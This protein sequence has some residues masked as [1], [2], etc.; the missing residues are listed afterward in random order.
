MIEGID[1]AWAHPVPAALVAAGKR[2]ACRYLSRDPGKN[3][4]AAEA[5]QLHAAG[6]ATVSNW[7]AA[8]GAARNGYAQGVA[9][10][11]AA[12]AQHAAA[13][14]PADRPIYFSVDFDVPDFAP[15][16]ADP[17]AKL[18]AVAGYFR[19]VASVIGVARTGAYGGFWAISRLFDAGLIRWGWQTFAWSGGHW[20]AR[21]QIQQYSNGV[22]VGGADSDLDRATVADYG[23]WG[24]GMTDINTPIPGTETPDHKIPRT[25]GEIEHDEAVDRA[26]RWGQR[27]VTDMPAD[28][29]GRKLLE[30]PDV[31]A[32]LAARLDALEAKLTAPVTVVL[33]AADREDI[34]A[35]MAVQ[36]VAQLGALRFEAAPPAAS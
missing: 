26:I 6:I 12:A 34:A 17:A 19:G 2:F 21:A 27:P 8:S 18:G 16:S 7:E 13:G 35:Q 28:S 20:D 9:D 22:T 29:P 15:G 24:V 30:L 31:L 25:E 1:Y 23:Q 36:V 11:Q 14:G 4:T 3:L 32:A 10:A 5:Q 33:S